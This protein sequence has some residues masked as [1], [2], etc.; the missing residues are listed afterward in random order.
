VVTLL[1]VVFTALAYS[2]LSNPAS[3]D[4][5]TD[6]FFLVILALLAAAL[7]WLFSLRVSIYS[8]GISK[9]TWFGSKQIRW[10]DIERFYYSATKR[11]VNFIPIGT[12]Y[13]F[14]LVDRE[15]NKIALTNSV[16]R[17]SDLGQRLISS[18]FEPLYRKA[19]Q[20]FDSGVE[21]EF[22]PIRLSRDRGLKIKR[23]FT[24]KEIP[25]NQVSEYR[26]DKG[27]F[28][29]FK[30]GEKRTTGPAISRIPNAYVLLGLLNAIYR[31]RAKLG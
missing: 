16:E 8:Y 30:K 31:P 4:F 21:L 9:Q 13:S 12:Y 22:G 26:I 18:T 7:A 10:Y 24:N 23:L 17:P 14:K 11:S 29:I 6:L 15:G 5:T 3:R 25:L 1:A 20:L 19:A 2:V 28:Y 27:H